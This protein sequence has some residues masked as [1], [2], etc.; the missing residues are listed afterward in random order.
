MNM[1]DSHLLLTA[2]PPPIK[3]IYKLCKRSHDLRGQAQFL[4]ADGPGLIGQHSPTHAIEGC[5]VERDHLRRHQLLDGVAR[6]NANNSVRGGVGGEFEFSQRHA[7][8]RRQALHD[9][10]RLLL[11]MR[12]LGV[13]E[14][15]A[16]GSACRTVS[17][18]W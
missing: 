17:R 18:R 15:V 1:F 3:R 10:H 12:G 6:G 14:R 11:R 5:A 13:F 2:A 8:R 16:G 9:L 7:R 4:S